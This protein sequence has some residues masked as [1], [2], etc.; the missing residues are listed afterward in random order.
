M[1]RVLYS[2]H[3]FCF[4]FLPFLASAVS[5][6]RRAVIDRCVRYLVPFFVFYTLS[7]I[8]FLV[9]E[10]RG[11]GMS[12][13]LKDYVLGLTIASAPLVD[14]ASGFQL[15]WF[16]PTLLALTILRGFLA[17]ASGRLLAI[18]LCA[19]LALHGLIGDAPKDIKTYV[20]FGLLIIIYVMPLG[21]IAGRLARGAPG[22][23]WLSWVMLT[24]FVGT[25]A[26]MI[27]METSVNLAALNLFT[28]AQLPPL[29]LHDANAVSAFVAL[30]G[31]SRLFPLRQ[32]WRA[33]G[34][35]SLEIYLFHSLIYQLLLRLYQAAV[36]SHLVLDQPV[37]AG[38]VLFVV[39][40]GLSYVA[41][42][43]GGSLPGWHLAFPR[44]LADWRRA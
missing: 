39:T 17:Q 22:G 16:L 12:G 21:M 38:T 7:A 20:P 19:F 43:I 35:H 30:V 14:R 5:L 26:A 6:N 4:L 42:R 8:L 23:G 18:I 24:M 13:W 28:Y 27:I 37:V 33:L 32:M 36:A 2:F 1:Q 3:V 41:A 10:Q 9:V 15:Y 34:R 29:L 44:L 25:S 31:L 11:Q 40:C